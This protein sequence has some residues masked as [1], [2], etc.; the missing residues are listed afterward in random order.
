MIVNILKYF[1]IDFKVNY[2]S[3]YLMSQKSVFISVTSDINHVKL[4]NISH[5]ICI[6]TVFL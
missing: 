5:Q 4:S 1:S 6:L 3:R 2:C